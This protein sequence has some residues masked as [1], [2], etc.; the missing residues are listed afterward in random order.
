MCC[1]V[2]VFIGSQFLE[3]I[4]NY[5]LSLIS[6]PAIYVTKIMGRLFP[7]YKYEILTQMIRHTPFLVILL[8]M[9]KSIDKFNK[10][11]GRQL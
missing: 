7:I 8:S 1:E 9:V 5:R 11:L 6:A 3:K 2:P 4:I 10:R